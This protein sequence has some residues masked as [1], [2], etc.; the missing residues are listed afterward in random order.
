[1]IPHLPSLHKNVRNLALLRE[2]LILF[3]ILSAFACQ[4]NFFPWQSS[5]ARLLSLQANKKDRVKSFFPL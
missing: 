3:R 2:N 5:P 4:K 1:M